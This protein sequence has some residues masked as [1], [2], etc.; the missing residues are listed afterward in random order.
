[1]KNY[2]AILVILALQ[3]CSENDQHSAK[4]P[5]ESTHTETQTNRIAIPPAVRANLGITFATVERRQ[6]QDTLRAPGRFE[7]L[8]SAKREYRT[9]LDGKV[10]ILVNQFE[11]VEKGTPL[12]RIDSPQWRED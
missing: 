9:M 2:L 6:L 12:Y 11:Q 7:Y 3:G 1:M 8:P 5:T 4:T 10:D